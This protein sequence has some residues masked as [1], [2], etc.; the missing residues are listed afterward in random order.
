MQ[1]FCKVKLSACLKNKNNKVVGIL[2]SLL[3]FPTATHFFKAILPNNYMDY[4]QN[5]VCF[6]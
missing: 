1:G 4:S 2:N 3:V 5:D 6:V